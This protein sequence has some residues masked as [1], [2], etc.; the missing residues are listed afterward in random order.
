MLNGALSSENT[1]LRTMFIMPLEGLSSSAQL[2][3]NSRCG[4]IIGMME[5]ILNRNLNGISVRVL[6]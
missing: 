2:T 6:R 1:F 4:I 3:E 5:M